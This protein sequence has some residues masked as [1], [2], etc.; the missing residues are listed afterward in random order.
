MYVS[1]K[2]GGVPKNAIGKLHEAVDGDR[3]KTTDMYEKRESGKM[4][5]PC[6]HIRKSEFD[7]ERGGYM[8]TIALEAEQQVKTVATE[9][10]RP[11]S[12]FPQEVSVFAPLGVLKEIFAAIDPR[13]FPDQKKEGVEGARRK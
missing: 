10:D 8:V 11:G 9:S 3:C 4:K 6:A 7:E 5:L 2:I 13:L 12:F 1:L